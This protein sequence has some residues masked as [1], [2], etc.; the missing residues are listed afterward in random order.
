MYIYIYI[1][2]IILKAANVLTTKSGDVK[3]TDFGVSRRLNVMDE[4]TSAVVGTPN[5]SMFH[6]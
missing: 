3:L 1:I 5:W 6:I 4:K 2:N